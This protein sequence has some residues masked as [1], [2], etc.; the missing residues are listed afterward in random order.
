MVNPPA[1]TMKEDK[2]TQW[3]AK[4]AKPS[5]LVRSLIK[6]QIPG[7]IE[8]RESRLREK[9]KAKRKPRRDSVAAKKK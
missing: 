2:I 8:A 5:A 1:I 6:K 9:I 3:I 7:L 4:G